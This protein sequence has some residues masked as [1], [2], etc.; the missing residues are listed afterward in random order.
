ML[1]KRKTLAVALMCTLGVSTLLVGCG[2]KAQKNS[3]AGQM[4]PT[5]VTYLTVKTEDLAIKTVLSGRTNAFYEAEVRP[6]VNGILEKRLFTEGAEVKAGQPLYLINPSPYKAALKSAEA[7]L[8]QARASLVKATADARR[9]SE[10]LKVKAVSQ[11]SDD[12]AQAAMKAA[13]AAVKASEAAVA[14]AKINLEYTNVCSPISGRIGRSEFTEGALMTAYQA[15]P[16][17]RVQQLD[18]IY[19]D[20]TQTADDMLRIQRDIASGKLKTDEAGHARVLLQYADGT[21]YEHEGTL[22]FTDVTVNETTGSVNLRAVFPNPERTLLPGLY[23]RATLIEGVR[24]QA[25]TVPM[26]SLMH[27]ARGNPYVFVITEENKVESRKVTATRTV[28]T[29]WLI[30]SGLKSGE[31]VMF[32]GFQRVRPGATVAP[33]EADTTALSVHGKPL[34]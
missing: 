34:F 16:L 19:V 18:P 2:D 31:R 25:I 6:Q 5:Q 30:D 12:A 33:V 1:P 21:V 32:E 20:I 23:V 28:G 11:Q 14:N 3:G 27:D 9:S 29:N 26:Q 22:M 17:T 4:P 15:Q 8:A 7:S 10:L 13:Q 24:P